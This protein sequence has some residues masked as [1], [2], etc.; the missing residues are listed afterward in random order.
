MVYKR[1]KYLDTRPLHT[2]VPT[3]KGGMPYKKE[4]A[5]NIAPHLGQQISETDKSKTKYDK[6]ETKKHT[7]QLEIKG[8]DFLIE[9]SKQPTAP[10][11]VTGG[12][13]LSH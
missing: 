13:S 5:T 3:Q 12:A 10:H 6:T 11:K 1:W 7:K 9:I 8:E 2:E 4:E